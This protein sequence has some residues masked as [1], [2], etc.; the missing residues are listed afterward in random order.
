M[1]PEGASDGCAVR[2][3]LLGGKT[4]AQRLGKTLCPEGKGT[5][6]SREGPFMQIGGGL[7]E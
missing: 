5:S 7:G 1:K 6:D 3:W 2:G 4:A